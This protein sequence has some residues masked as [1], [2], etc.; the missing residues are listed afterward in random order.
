MQTEPIITKIKKEL[1]ELDM[2]LEGMAHYPTVPTPLIDLTESKLTEVILQLRTLKAPTE[3]VP[4]QETLLEPQTIVEIPVP[5]G[6]PDV[7]K[8][9][10]EQEA[11][12][13][14]EVPCLTNIA[15][16]ELASITELKEEVV[17]T[18]K[19][20]EKIEEVIEPSVIT[21]TIDPIKNDISNVIPVKNEQIKEVSTPLTEPEITLKNENLKTEEKSFAE[22][23]K[24]TRTLSESHQG[25]ISRNDSLAEKAFSSIGTKIEQSPITDIKRAI[26]LNDRFRFQRE[27]FNGDNQLFNNTLQAINELNNIDEAQELIS[28]TFN[29]NYEEAITQEFIQLIHRRF[30]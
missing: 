12:Q 23:P 6:E 26:N 25:S 15:H 30:I 7:S 10:T 27:L 4:K 18:A 3:E 29:W 28:S 22:T 14:E 16:E 20:E 17:E 8:Q 24:I 11:P 1:K 21:N 2:L 9:P 5:I 13:T 19:E